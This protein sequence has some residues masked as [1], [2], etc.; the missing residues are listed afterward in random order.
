VQCAE[1]RLSALTEVSRELLRSTAEL[2]DSEQGLLAVLI[3][4][5]YAAY[6]FVAAADRVCAGEAPRAGR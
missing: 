4:Y 2:P 1:D 3:E 5:N 6:A